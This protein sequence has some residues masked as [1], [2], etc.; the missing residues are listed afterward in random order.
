MEEAIVEVQY[1]EADKATVSRVLP[2]A[3]Q[4]YKQLMAN[5][6]VNGKKIFHSYTWLIISTLSMSCLSY[7]EISRFHHQFHL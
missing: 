1:R 5:A 4:E 2:E 6:G 7:N 3:V